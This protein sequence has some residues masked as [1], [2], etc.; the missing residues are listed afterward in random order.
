MSGV[1]FGT[2]LSTAKSKI[3]NALQKQ[4]TSTSTS[5]FTPMYDLR[6]KDVNAALFED[7]LKR[8]ANPVTTSTASPEN[9]DP[10]KDALKEFND[11]VRNRVIGPW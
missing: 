9:Y 6:V 1:T 2:I 11:A 4:S 3:C 8:N 10:T 7:L 5:K